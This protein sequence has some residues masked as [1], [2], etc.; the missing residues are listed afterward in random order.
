MTHPEQHRSL[1]FGIGPRI[2]PVTFALAIIA[3]LPLLA[4]QSA[5]AQTLAVIHDFTYNQQ[6][7]SYARLVMDKRG[8]L[9]GTASGDGAAGYG[10]V[11]KLTHNESG[12]VFSPLYSFQGGSD[13]AYP[14][15]GL[16]FGPDGSLYGTTS[17]GGGSYCPGSQG[18]GTVLKL[19][20]PATACK[21]A[22]CPWT[23]T[24][25][26][27]FTG[28][29][30]GS[31]PT[32]GVIFDPGGNIYGTAY[33]GGKSGQGCYGNDCGVVFKLT[34]SASSW[35]ES[36]I[37]SF[38]GAP[39]GANPSRDLIFDKAGNL[40]GTTSYGGYTAGS[41]T[42][43]G[44]GTVFQLTPSGSGWAGNVLYTFT[45]QSD[46]ATPF[47]GLVFDSSGNLY[48]ATIANQGDVGT[49]FELSPSN[50]NW[51]FT[52]LTTLN[53]LGPQDTLAID[54]AGN[55]Y[56][57]ATGRRDYTPGLVF[58]LTASNNGWIYSTLH[59]FTFSDGGN[60]FG[61]VL[62]DGAGNLYGTTYDGGAY[63]QGV[64][65]EITP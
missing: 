3:M 2:A 1:I 37:H 4:T 18:C 42:K 54:G 50:G 63:G 8:N 35:T 31:F 24:V 15:G 60:P 27:S 28:G 43:L 6:G 56:G 58:K 21:T 25:L 61:G 52:L 20:P 14:V 7:N 12:W 45:G 29:S 47:C 59:N 11:F 39:D 33:Y 36:S 17:Q 23:E 48:G 22:L 34:R 51:T 64:V 57:V 16:T 10:M 32:G 44:C 19:S 46:G 30:D 9:Y 62:L 38:S 41:C 55:L 49:V 40:Y 53:D 5:Q 65:W 26:Y 13:G